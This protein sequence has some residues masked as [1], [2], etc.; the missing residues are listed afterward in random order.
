MG[1]EALHSAAI[2][3]LQSTLDCQLPCQTTFLSQIAALR[4]ESLSLLKLIGGAATS[5]I[6]RQLYTMKLISIM[7]MVWESF[8]FD[9]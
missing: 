1:D 6:E 3:Q 4:Q 7:P 5:T 8:T 2:L 9:E